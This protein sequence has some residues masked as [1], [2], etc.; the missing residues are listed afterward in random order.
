[1]IKFPS[2]RVALQKCIGKLVIRSRYIFCAAL[3]KAL[4]LTEA[5]ISLQ[6]KSSL[7][8]A[9]QKRI[10]KLLLKVFS[11]TGSRYIFLRYASKNTRTDGA[12]FL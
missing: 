7:R 11:F 9:L 4:E 6:G 1:M 10:G 3:R 12:T 5:V 2:L 8:V